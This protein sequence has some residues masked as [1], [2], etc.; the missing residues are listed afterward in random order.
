M[1]NLILIIVI[2]SLSFH[3]GP[4]QDEVEKTIEDGV[5]VVIN[6]LD[7]YKVKGEPSNLVLEEELTIDTE[8]DEIGELGLIDIWS[9]DVDSEENIYLLHLQSKENCIFKFNREGNFISSFGRRGQG[10]GEMQYPIF[11]QVINSEI[12]VTDP[13]KVVFFS[14]NGK[15]LKETSKDTNKLS[16]ICLKNGNFLVRENFRDISDSTTRYSGLILYDSEFNQIKEIDR[17]PGYPFKGDG[18]RA[19]LPYIHVCVLGDKIFEGNSER[20]YEIHA[21]DLNGNL[22]KKIKK[23]YNPVPINEQDKERILKLFEKMPEEIKKTIYFPDNFPPFQRLFFTDDEGRLFVMTYEKGEKPREF[24]YDIFNSEGVFIGRIGF[25]NYGQD[26][27]QMGPLPAL[28]KNGL[29]YF[30]REKDNGYK[31]LVVSRMNWE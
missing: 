31:E 7:P 28:S 26:A 29:L 17:G 23:E 4:K 15:F 18:Y 16:V 25:D 3:C 12:A 11:F 19:I 1:K 24:I 13:T 22:I 5:E 20:E 8:K 2:L 27:V 30:V 21:Y 6:H 9:F 14:N 10:P